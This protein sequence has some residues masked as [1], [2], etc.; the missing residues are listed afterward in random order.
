MSNWAVKSTIDK[1][2]LDLTDIT[3]QL[4]DRPMILCDVDEVVLE[5]LTPFMD[6][7]TSQGVQLGCNT[8]ALNGNIFDLETGIVQSNQSVNKLINQFY[9]DQNEWQYPVSQVHAVLNRLSEK[10]DIVFLTAMP[11]QFRAQRQRLLKRYDFNYPIIAQETAKGPLSKAVH[12]ARSQP[13][14]FIDDML[15]NHQS[16]HQHLPNA[17]HIFFM[18]N[19]TFK[20]LAPP[21][22]PYIYNAHDW[23]DIE[24]HINTTLAQS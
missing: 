22:D 11:E 24:D 18:A 14:F 13:I 21:L 1:P 2:L 12:Q 19:G 20:K 8:F 7:L 4:Q 3:N 6:F 15:Y 10:S 9:L 17:N 23:L 16:V 5:F